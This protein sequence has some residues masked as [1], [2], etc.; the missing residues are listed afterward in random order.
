MEECLVTN[1][2]STPTLKWQLVE[3]TAEKRIL[4]HETPFS[5]VNLL[6]FRFRRYFLRVLLFLPGLVCKK[7]VDRLWCRLE[8]SETGPCPTGASNVPGTNA[9][10]VSGNFNFNSSNSG[11]GNHR[12]ASSFTNGTS[13]TRKLFKRLKQLCGRTGY[14]EKSCTFGKIVRSATAQIL[15]KF[16]IRRAFCHSFW[17]FPLGVRQKVRLERL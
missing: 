7:G 12:V 15:L 10:I 8:G 4:S 13:K 2:L 1:A 5:Q 3:V 6:H 11:G 17:G 16:K 14:F 9:G